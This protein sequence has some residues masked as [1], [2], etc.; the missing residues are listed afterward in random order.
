MDIHGRGTHV[1]GTHTE[2][3]LYGK[4]REDM[5][6]DTYGLETIWK[7]QSLRLIRGVGVWE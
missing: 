6:R 1:V 3:R 7:K 2:K 4:E 5:E